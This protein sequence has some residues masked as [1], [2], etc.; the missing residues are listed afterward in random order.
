[1]MSSVAD[2]ARL[3]TGEP[4]EPVWSADLND[5]KPIFADPRSVTPTTGV[6]FHPVL[7]R[8]LLTSF[9]TGPGQLGV[10]EGPEPWGPWKTVAYYQ[11]WGKMGPEGHGLNCDFP[12]KW[13]SDDGS[14]MWCVFSVYGRG[15]GKGIK[16]HDCFNLVK[17]TLSHMSK[18]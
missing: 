15:A 16:T 6:V 18:Q 9:H 5:I 17:V 12:Q 1:M 4:T 2:V 7:R 14:T 8:Y 13:M 10:F 3:Q 11:D